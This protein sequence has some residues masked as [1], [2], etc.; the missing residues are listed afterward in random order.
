MRGVFTKLAYELQKVITHNPEYQDYQFRI[1]YELDGNGCLYQIEKKNSNK[2]VLAKFLLDKYQQNQFHF[3][4]SI[5]SHP[6]DEGMHQIMRARNQYAI[7]VKKEGPND[8]PLETSASHQLEDHE[9]VIRL[10][11]DLAGIKN[12]DH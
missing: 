8:M 12:T 4:L 5:G 9:N 11:E 3:A 10:L 2:G 7:L 1:R 6:V